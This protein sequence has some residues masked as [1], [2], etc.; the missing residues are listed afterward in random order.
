MTSEAQKE[1]GRWLANYHG[2]IDSTALVL[3]FEAGWQASRAP[4]P[5]EDDDYDSELAVMLSQML[6][7][8][9]MW[10]CV[11]IAKRLHAAG[12][13]RAP[14]GPAVTDEMV[15]RR[16]REQATNQQNRSQQ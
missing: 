6:D 5:T 10:S 16:L 8:E 7:D 15:E 14:A 1:A 3:A 11:V 4:Q 2:S 12:F 13:R 9:P